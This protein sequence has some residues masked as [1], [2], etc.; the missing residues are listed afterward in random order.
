MI[1]TL[2]M[3][4]KLFLTYWSMLP[5]WI[6][7]LLLGAAIYLCVFKHRAPQRVTKLWLLGFIQALTPK[8]DKDTRTWINTCTNMILNNDKTPLPQA[9]KTPPQEDTPQK[10]R[11]SFQKAYSESRTLRIVVWLTIAVTIAEITVL[12]LKAL[13]TI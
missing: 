6:Q 8:D 2:T 9:P 4:F 12:L 7:L 11:T 3:P 10:P 13:G 5:W 1:E